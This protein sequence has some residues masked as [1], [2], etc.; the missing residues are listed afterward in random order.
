M[1]KKIV[2][3]FIFSILLISCTT[4]NEQNPAHP[5]SAVPPSNAQSNEATINA[6]QPGDASGS[7]EAQTNEPQNKSDSSVVPGVD[8]SGGP[9]VDHREDVDAA[10]AD[11]MTASDAHTQQSDAHTQ[12][13]VDASPVVDS[14]APIGLCDRACL[15]QFLDEY[16]DALVASDSSSLKVAPNLRATENAQDIALGDG[17]MA[18]ATALRAFRED[19]V[20]VVQ[21]QAGSFAVVEE[22]GAPALMSL[23]LRV[24]DHQITEIE[25]IVTRAGEHLFFAPD[26]LVAADPI[27]DEIVP[28][29]Q[30]ST[31]ED[32]ERL[33][34]AYFDGLES[35]DGSALV[36]DE[37]C[38]RLENGIVTASGIGIGDA[39]IMFVYIEE[40]KRRIAIVDEERGLAFGQTVF[41]MPSQS[42]S[43]LIGELFK[44]IGGRFRMIPAFMIN[45]PY[46][47]V[48]GW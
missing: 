3:R 24:V 8:S 17:L 38:Q 39:F 37:Q 18:T 16:Y 44:I 28:E 46:G 48:S 9:S 22:T 25:T 15:I 35:A 1:T 36:F 43:A 13:T 6:A 27:F 7:V 33:A 42:R 31:R 14:S 30:R 2:S 29:A 4:S 40:V 10:F 5:D 26:S 19:F 20:D 41:V 45:V 32:L 21:G 23:R 11:G 12:Q 47:T 34:N